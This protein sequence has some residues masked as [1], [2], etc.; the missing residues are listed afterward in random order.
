MQD[1][2]FLLE[3]KEKEKVIAPDNKFVFGAWRK[4]TINCCVYVSEEIFLFVGFIF[5]VY[6]KDYRTIFSTKDVLSESDRHVLW[7]AQRSIF[8]TH[9]NFVCENG[10]YILYIFHEIKGKGNEFV[11]YSSLMLNIVQMK[12]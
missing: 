11:R 1:E 2:V 6:D 5:K 3:N 8:S 10:K 9:S 7:L 4:L 12:N